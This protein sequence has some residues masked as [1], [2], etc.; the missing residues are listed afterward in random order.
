[1]AQVHSGTGPCRYRSLYRPY[2][3]HRRHQLP[4]SPSGPAPGLPKQPRPWLLKQPRPPRRCSRTS[5]VGRASWASREP[6]SRTS[7]WP[8]TEAY[9]RDWLDAGFNGHMEYMARHGTKRSRPAELLPGTVSCISVR[10]DYWPREAA[11][12]AA[13]LA[14]GT[15][16]YLSR[17]ALGRDYHKLMRRRLQTLCERIAL[18]IGPFGYRA[19]RRQRARSGEGVGA[20]CRS[21]LDRQTHQPDRQR[22]GL[23]FFPGRDL[24]GSRI[25]VRRGEHRALRYLQRVPAGVPYRCHRGA[26]SA[27]R[28]ALHLLSHHRTEGIHPAGVSPRHRQPRLWLRRLPARLPLETNLHGRP[29]KRTLRSATASTAPGWSICSP[30]AKRSSPRRRAAAP[31]AVSATR[32]GYANVAVALGNAPTSDAVVAALRARADHSSPLVREHVAWALAEHAA[33]GSATA[34]ATGA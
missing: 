3:Q 9:F 21:R 20:Q 23:L 13:T 12:P 1:M 33:R 16:G 22:C 2:A 25:A 27:R 5:S 4:G 10:M 14:D 11:D 30:G 18:A 26:L 6:A 7:I 31:S 24:C 32:A 8:P 34:A 29:A 17:Y 28:A 19:F 15:L